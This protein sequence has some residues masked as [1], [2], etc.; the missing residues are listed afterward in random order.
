MA[1]IDF[2]QATMKTLSEQSQKCK[3]RMLMPCDI[4]VIIM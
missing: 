4:H 3:V 1:D 2:Y